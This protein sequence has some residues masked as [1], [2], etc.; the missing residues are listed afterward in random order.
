MVGRVSRNVERPKLTWSPSRTV[1]VPQTRRPFTQVPLVEPRSLTYQDP[2]YS[3]SAAWIRDVESSLIT[4]S[5]SG[6]R[7]TTVTGAAESGSGSV[8]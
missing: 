5:Q 1:T 7:P 3:I 8:G 6:L 2:A 4:K